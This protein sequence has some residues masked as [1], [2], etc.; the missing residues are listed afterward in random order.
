MTLD[1]AQ[2]EITK[3]VSDLDGYDSI[4][5]TGVWR[6]G[7]VKNAFSAFKDSKG[8]V[9]VDWHPKRP[10][11]PPSAAASLPAPALPDAAASLPA[12]SPAAE[13]G[14]APVAALPEAKPA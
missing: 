12:P 4:H 13:L 3:A 8:N 9:T 5:I 7:I 14:A 1:Q 11:A 2:A 6:E 10:P